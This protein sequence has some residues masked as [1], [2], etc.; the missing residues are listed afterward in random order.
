[1]CTGPF[2]AKRS[3]KADCGLVIRVHVK[4][5]FEPRSQTAMQLFDQGTSD[6]RTLPF[7]EYIE[8]PKVRAPV[9]HYL[10]VQVGDHLG[11]SARQ[12]TFALGHEEV[13]IAGLL[14]FGDLLGYQ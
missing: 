7:R 11:G 8:P 1:M 10:E 14:R 3:V 9:R 13:A 2:G 4:L 5:V 6:A 12:G